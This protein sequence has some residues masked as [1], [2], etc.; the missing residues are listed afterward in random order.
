MTDAP[1]NGSDEDSPEGADDATRS[2]DIVRTLG[3]SGILLFAGTF[4]ELGISFL[5]KLIVARS[6]LSFGYGE[7]AVGLTILTV[8]VILTRLG[9]DTGVARIAPR[10]DG[11]ERADVYLTGYVTIIL[12]TLVGSIVLFF[13]AGPLATFLGNPGLTPVL[14]VIAIGIPSLP[15]MKVS[16]GIIR[17]E[18]RSGPKVVV[19]NLAHP[20]TRI[21]FVAAVALTGASPTRI[22]A[23]Y[24]GSHWFA[25]LLAVGFVYRTKSVSLL[26]HS[27]TPRFRELLGYSFPLMLSASMAFIIGNTDNLMIQYFLNSGEVGIYDIAYTLGETLTIAL[28]AFGF[29]Y[30]P[31][32]SKLHAEQDWEEIHYLYQL[33]TKWVIF[34]TLPGFLV[35]ALFPDTVIRYTFGEEYVAGAPILILIALTYFIRAAVGPNSG[36]LEAIGETRFILKGNIIAGVANILLNLLLIP[37]LGV[38]GAAIASF[39]SF[40]TLN[41][42][43]SYRL[44]QVSGLR[45]VT[46][47][48]VVPATVFGLVTVMVVGLARTSIDLTARPLLLAGLACSAAIFYAVTILSLGGVESGDIMLLNSMEDRFDIDLEPIKS[49][50]RRLL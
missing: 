17:A 2:N 7:V 6:L 29:L 1:Q 43:Y 35:L 24:V 4:L 8:L 10:Y 19:Q 9:V 49:V 50:A 5:A 18:N 33:V 47:N 46:R 3:K 36:T 27:W 31:N 21:G 25:S 34:I 20:I 48:A 38:I 12:S 30:L 41:G 40:T 23:A 16:I 15:I 37:G 14:R 28:G 44:W 39:V 32:A 45:P 22:A 11:K 42:V 13:G 26:S